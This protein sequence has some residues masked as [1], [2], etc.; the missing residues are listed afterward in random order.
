MRAEEGMPDLPERARVSLAR[1]RE[2][3]ARKQKEEALYQ[4][5]DLRYRALTAAMM[6][7]LEAPPDADALE[8]IIAQ[9]AQMNRHGQACNDAI[10]QGREAYD[11]LMRILQEVGFDLFDLPD[12]EALRSMH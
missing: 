12:E 10:A 7:N 3:I 8:A 1:Y 5:A 11:E 6:Q 2:A 4:E 9:H